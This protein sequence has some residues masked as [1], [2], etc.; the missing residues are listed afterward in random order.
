MEKRAG[1]GQRIGERIVA[2]FREFHFTWPGFWRWSGIV[3]FAVLF[4]ALVTLYFLDWN[5]LR[6]PIGHYTSARG[7]REVRI[8]GD[9]KV[10]LFRRQPHVSVGALYIGNPS[11]VG[12]PQAARIGRLDVEFRLFPA[13]FGRWILPLVK[14][15]RPE[16]LLV[17]DPQGRTNWDD[18][19]QGAAASWKIPPIQ[20]FVLN[21]GHIEIDDAVRKLKFLGLVS[22]Q[23]QGGGK[24]AFTLN[25]EG[26][27]NGA[28][29][30][31]NVDGGPLI[32]V[33]VSKPYAFHADIRAGDT[34]ALIDGA[35][36]RPFALTQFHAQAQ[37]SGANLGD[38]Y[39]LT[40]LALPGTPPYRLSGSLTRDGNSY[41]FTGMNGTV[42]KSDLKGY[43]NVDVSGQIPNLKGR[44]S[45]HV[46]DMTDLGALFRGGK[47][48]GPQE[49]YLL[50]DTVLH[51]EKLRQVNGEVDY[52]ADTIHSRDFP[53]RGF[54]THISVENAVL[55]LKPLAFAFTEGKLSGALTIDAH[56]DV[57]VT[58]VDARITDIHI[59]H[60]IKS[61]DKPLSGMVEARAQ[62][63]GSGNS[64]HKVGASA[65]GMATFVVPSGQ[66]RR[67]VAA[68][69]GVN[70][71]DAL[72]LTLSGDK[73]NT[74]VR[75]AVAH[76]TAKDGQLT[77]QR[78]ILD[79]DPV[80]VDGSGTVNLKDETLD[81]TLQGKPK[82][83]QLLR[84]KAPITVSG[85]LVSPSLGVNAQPAVTQ[86]LLGAGLGL[87]MPLASIFA[88][89]DPGLAKDANCAALLS[90][91]KAQG[92]PVKRSAVN[93]A[94][95]K[96]AAKSKK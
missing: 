54:S 70:V 78:F 46:L 28:K 74:E 85:K 77:T 9:L 65:N 51:T 89:I 86:G 61:A 4:A 31:A 22:S 91:A 59:E 12:A 18:N 36:D 90:D 34:H 52:A 44:L 7:G 35:I 73:G 24:A 66:I 80:R 62:L 76:F 16:L 71:I 48:A 75:C 63:K 19:S 37:F 88:F 94:A 60:F 5:Q 3:L 26:T 50:P 1:P 17:R 96:D 49:Q 8:D 82:S 15:D 69:L 13:L 93:K 72:G 57:P 83:F 11:W 41:S 23:E 79:T 47:A 32:H 30:L 21:D 2:D 40:G 10:D 6:G 95:A 87:L 14:I 20:N 29:F 64:V 81:L 68:W 39:N 45:S 67:S 33:D 58:G 55:T 53:L 43:L 92:A 42:G 25:G 38:L 27:L 84:L 56:N